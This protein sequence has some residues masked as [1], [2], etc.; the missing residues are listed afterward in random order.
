MLF[1]NAGN[2]LIEY[3]GELAYTIMI[4]SPRNSNQ[5]SIIAIYL[6]WNSISS[7]QST[8][9]SPLIADIIVSSAKYRIG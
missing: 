6:V 8:K 9:A 3:I 7:N 2:Y 1:I 5:F 4:P